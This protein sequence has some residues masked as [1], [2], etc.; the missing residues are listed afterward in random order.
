MDHGLETQVSLDCLTSAGKSWVSR[1]SRLTQIIAAT[2]HADAI[3]TALTSSASIDALFARN[4]TLMAIAEVKCRDMGY[5]QLHAYGS[6]L[7]TN[8]KIK[9]GC[10][11]SA[12]L[13][14]PFFLFVGLRTDH[15]IVYWQMSDAEGTRTADTVVSLTATKRTCNDDTSIDRMNAYIDL[16]TMRELHYTGDTSW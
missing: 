9:R 16:A 4:G 11:I 3:E 14:V 6:Y 15:R 13:Q 5:E 12:D 10:R 7:I 2:Y 8:D 1:Q